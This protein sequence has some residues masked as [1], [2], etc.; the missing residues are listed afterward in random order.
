MQPSALAYRLVV[1]TAYRKIAEVL[2]GC[3]CFLFHGSALAVDGKAYLFTAPSGTGKSTHAAIWRR[4]YGER[5]VM[6][7]DDK[8]ILRVTPEAVYACGSP[9]NGSHHLDTPVQLPLCGLCLLARSER[10]SIQTVSVRDA[11]PR[12]LGQCYRPSSPEQLAA[13]LRLIDALC[14][15]VPLYELHCNMEDDAAKT[16]YAAMFERNGSK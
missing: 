16:A 14:R 11:Y 7:N 2:P 12:L 6:I 4:L 9:W 13:T 10:N 5:V 8:P 1:Q 15:K 3:G